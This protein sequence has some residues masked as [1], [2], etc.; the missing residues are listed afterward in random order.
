MYLYTQRLLLSL[1]SWEWIIFNEL[2][3]WLSIHGMQWSKSRPVPLLS[4]QCMNT[5]SWLLCPCP[6]AHATGHLRISHKLPISLGKHFK[7]L[8]N[9]VNIHDIISM[10]AQIIQN[11]CLTYPPHTCSPVSDQISSDQLHGPRG[12]DTTANS[13]CSCTDYNLLFKGEEQVEICFIAY[14]EWIAKQPVVY[15]S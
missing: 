15:N 12:K 4:S 6:L 14:H 11:W 1:L 2:T 3:A 7:I 8:P 9:V 13:L 5:M 10:I